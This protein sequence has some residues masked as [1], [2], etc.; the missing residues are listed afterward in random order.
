MYLVTKEIMRRLD[1]LH[2][3]TVICFRHVPVGIYSQPIQCYSTNGERTF[4]G[5]LPIFPH[6]P[7]VPYLRLKTKRKSDHFR[8]LLAL[9]HSRS[10]CF[11]IK[12]NVEKKYFCSLTFYFYD[13]NE[14]LVKK[15]DQKLGTRFFFLLSLPVSSSF[16][17]K[18]CKVGIQNF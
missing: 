17:K 11:L 2:F 6:P 5:K 13:F 1:T 10:V 4:P 16:I 8:C 7:S 9:I 15:A 12:R 3:Q 14:I 18:I